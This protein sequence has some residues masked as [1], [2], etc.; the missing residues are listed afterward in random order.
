MSRRKPHAAGT[1]GAPINSYTDVFET[2]ATGI[3]N[4]HWR[5]SM[6]IVPGHSADEL[7]PLLYL[8]M[9]R[10]GGFF[11]SQMGVGQPTGRTGYG[12]EVTLR[13]NDDGNLRAC[14]SDVLEDGLTSSRMAI[15][16]AVVTVSATS[17]DIDIDL[18]QFPT[19]LERGL[20]W[21]LDFWRPG[22][23]SPTGRMG[24][25]SGANLP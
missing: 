3:T 10:S 9:D 19:S 14:E 13:M 18:S 8:D 21:E 11:S 15:G 2:P 6:P 17:L 25:Y 5:M 22:D 20:A 16:K 4:G 23:I 1:A 7:V 24:G 12:A